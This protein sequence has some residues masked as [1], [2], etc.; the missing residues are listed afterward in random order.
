MHHCRYPP[1]VERLDQYDA[2]VL[3]ILAFT[4]SG[5]CCVRFSIDLLLSFSYS[6]RYSP[7]RT[8]AVSSLSS[9]PR[10][11]TLIFPITSK[12]SLRS[13][14]IYPRS[15]AITRLLPRTAQLQPPM[16][17][18]HYCKCRPRRNNLGAG[19]GR[20]TLSRRFLRARRFV[21][22][23]AF[24]QFKDTEDWR[25]EHT[26]DDIFNNIEV[27]EFEQTRRLVRHLN[28]ITWLEAQGCR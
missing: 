19:H 21:P 10:G 16:T 13:L 24:K 7:W 18:R 17:M 12:H 4:L 27:E 3:F 28:A 5:N 6:C 8:S 14:R 11:I 26:I 1:H 9:T 22:A 25:K 20:L 2:L 23:E 15:R